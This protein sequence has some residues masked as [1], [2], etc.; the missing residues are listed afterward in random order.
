LFRKE[1][2]NMSAQACSKLDALEREVIYRIYVKEQQLI[3]IAHSLGYSRCHI[4]RVKKK[5][6]DA[7]CDNLALSVQGEAGKELAELKKRLAAE[8]TPS[9]ER[10]RVHRRRPRSKK[11]LQERARRG[12][13]RIAA[14]A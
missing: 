6:L 12:L 8:D 2:L 14:A 9:I 3:D 10:R 4:S 13:D 11:A 5:A 7:L 1:L